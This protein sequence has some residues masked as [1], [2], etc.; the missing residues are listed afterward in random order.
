M[1]GSIPPRTMTRFGRSKASVSVPSCG[2][3]A[4][5]QRPSP[6][7]P[8][9]L[10]SSSSSPRRRALDRSLRCPPREM[11]RQG[12]RAPTVT[13]ATV[14]GEGD[15][16]TVGAFEGAG[17]GPGSSVSAMPPPTMKAISPAIVMTSQVVRDNASPSRASSPPRVNVTPR[18]LQGCA[19][20][21][22]STALCCDDDTASAGWSS[23]FWGTSPD[24]KVRE[25]R[26]VSELLVDFIT[27]LDGYGAAEGWPG[28]WGLQGRSTSSG[29]VSD[30]TPT[31]RS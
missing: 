13:D 30:R 11:P 18:A 27:S 6:P 19:I 3:E 2:P 14:S 12:R 26:L 25:E 23:C 16:L 28:W 4:R 10:L 21:I 22:A 20:R 17:L 8:C 31:T 9:P 7:P 29:W 1:S 15:T 5:N 24:E